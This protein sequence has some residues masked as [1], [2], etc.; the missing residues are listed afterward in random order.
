MMQSKQDLFDTYAQTCLKKAA[1]V[2]D[3]K[4]KA[5]YRDLSAQWS[6]LAVISQ[7]LSYDA[8]DERNSSRSF[9]SALNLAAS[10][11]DCCSFRGERP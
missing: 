9:Y 5:L 2:Q 3:L 1:T 7:G 10:R 6:E 4:L 8:T 11:S